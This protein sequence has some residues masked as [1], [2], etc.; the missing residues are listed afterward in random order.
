M[1]DE[2]PVKILALVSA[3]LVAGEGGR[4]VS[5]LGKRITEVLTREL[6]KIRRAADLHFVVATP[7]N[8]LEALRD[9][10]PFDI[11]HYD[12]HGVPGALL[13]E[14]GKGGSIKVGAARLKAMFAPEPRAP[15][16][17]AVLSACHSESMAQAFA[18][19]GVPHVIAIDAEQAVLD[20]APDAFAEQFYPALFQGRS[21]WQAF[22]YGT[23][24]V[25]NDAKVRRA[26]GLGETEDADER[27]INE[28]LKFRPYPRKESEEETGRL[29]SAV[30]FESLPEGEL[31]VSQSIGQHPP[32]IPA[33]PPYF[34]GREEDLHAVINSVLEQPLTTVTGIGGMGK[35]ELCRETGR[36][37]A[38]RG[39]FAG[40]I[41]F[42]KLGAVRRAE[43]ARLNIAGALKID[44][45]EAETLDGLARALADD[46][47]LILDELDEMVHQDAQ[48]TRA[49]VEA[50]VGHGKARIL[51]ASRS[52]TGVQGEKNMQLRRMP[53]DSALRLLI[54]MAEQPG[55]DLQGQG[56]DLDEVMRF[57]DGVPRAI[58]QA[59]RQMITA[60]LAQLAAD[61]RRSREE[62]LNDP[63]IPE[64]ELQDSDSVLVTLN[65]SYRR[66]EDTNKQAAEFFPYL[67]LFPAGI[68]SDGLREVF[69]EEKARLIQPIV[70]RALVEIAPPLDYFYLPAPVRSYAERK[71]PARAMDEIATKA[72]R[73]LYGRAQEY[74]GAIT[75]G[76]IEA[77]VA[78]FSNEFPNLEPF[79]AW[80]YDREAPNTD[81]PECLS[82]RITSSFKNFFLF[83]DP[84][85]KQ[86]WR[87]EKALRAAQRV[88]DRQ[89][90]ADTR[91]AIGD[92]QRFRQEN[93]EAL[94]SYTQA[95]ALYRA[96]GER[97]GEANTLQAIGDVQRFRAENDEALASYTQALALYRAVGERLGEAN[98][99][100]A[101][102]DVQRF[103]N[104]N[105][106]AL[107]S[108]TQALALSRAVGERLGEANTRKAIG[109]IQKFRNENDEALASYTQALALYRAVG[110]RLGEANTRVAIGDVQRFRK[111]NDE[112]LASY[113]QALELFRAVGERLGEAR[114]LHSIGDV[115]DFRNE[116][117]E[118]LA[119][120][121][122][123]LELFRAVGNRLGEAN[124]LRAIGHVQ[125]LRQEND[126][127]LAS[128]TQALALYRAVGDRLGE[129]NTSMAIGD[130][131]QA[132]GEGEA[133]FGQ[134][135]QALGIYGEVGD[136]VGQAHVLLRLGRMLLPTKGEDKGIE[137]LK[138]ARSIYEAVDDQ[139]GLANVG[140]ALA[141][142]SAAKGDMQ[143]AIDHLQPVAD[144]CKRINHP[145]GDQHQAQIDEW[146]RQLE[147]GGQGAST[148]DG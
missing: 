116:T 135:Q 94:A 82:G 68:G 114:A 14:D 122:Q 121:T 120:Y 123:A 99:R 57:L 6:K 110:E 129:A 43:D 136:Q 128:Y 59:A 96:V 78:L 30:L 86:R 144:F 58:V 93:D 56:K 108:Y 79:L 134:Y 62:I 5:Q 50:L 73:Y 124:T 104:E 87:Y 15:A 13:F 66:L 126:E 92:V 100:K 145:F 71:L 27:N 127:A 33:R 112:A 138:A 49:L 70:Q 16:K 25:Y 53:R 19:A 46:S 21:V 67:A 132:L 38:E 34:T 10:G 148:G 85:G 28:V 117:D 64:E 109:D 22:Q 146:R 65:S 20:V 105:D 55:A 40:G 39:F 111:E 81:P 51:I 23:A 1:P 42:V 31:T 106:E 60:D 107:A 137:H 80:G 101:I 88:G 90:E 35:S 143:A 76:E 141:S 26:C 118:A 8:L 140:L 113:T 102:G 17:L 77:G 74:D 98:T 41:T 4:P 97:L 115:Q 75:S 89:A 54:E 95:L 47:L 130:F 45:R 44:P 69:G 2:R 7:E 37:F 18:D 139:S 52:L 147:A 142:H 32:S 24:M 72:L 103:R 63:N 48:A 133:A 125:K 29:H 36:W 84:S 9:Q 83:A 131:R 91:K 11:L 12:G 61:L 3:P 119:S